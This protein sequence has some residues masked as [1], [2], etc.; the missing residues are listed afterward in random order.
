M[1]RQN[2]IR[3][4]DRQSGMFEATRQTKW[5]VTP[6]CPLKPEDLNFISRDERG[7]FVW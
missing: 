1:A 3:F 2:I 7:C 4:V 6:D 5:V